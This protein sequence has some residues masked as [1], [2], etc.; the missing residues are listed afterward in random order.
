MFL[1]DLLA[2]QPVPRH[3]QLPVGGLREPGE[4]RGSR[5]WRH[6][7]VEAEQT[8]LPVDLARHAGAGNPPRRHSLSETA[9]GVDAPHG[10]DNV[11]KGLDRIV[12]NAAQQD[13][14]RRRAQEGAAA[15]WLSGD[16]HHPYTGS[17]SPNACLPCVLTWSIVVSSN[18][19]S[20][21]RARRKAPARASN[22]SRSVVVCHGMSHRR[23]SASRSSI[24]G[25]GDAD[26]VRRWPVDRGGQPGRSAGCRSLARLA[27]RG[28]PGKAV[29]S[30]GRTSRTAA[31]RAG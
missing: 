8:G 31:A 15:P 12:R 19:F 2:E 21:G 18:V 3:Q 5:I 24:P 14:V 11:H 4:T 28:G 30:R 27:R 7:S 26:P 9:F 13:R 25:R 20:V 10:R 22:R 23:C 16:S 29:R 1:T 6:E 17:S